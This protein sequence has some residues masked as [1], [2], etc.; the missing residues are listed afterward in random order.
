MPVSS[1]ACLVLCLSCPPNTQSYAVESV[2]TRVML[3]AFLKSIFQHQMQFHFNSLFMLL[4]LWFS[5]CTSLLPIRCMYAWVTS[6]EKR[7][8]RGRWK[9]IT[10]ENGQIRVILSK[11]VVVVVVVCV[12]V[13]VCTFRQVCSIVF[14]LFTTHCES[15]ND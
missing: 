6:N 12:C 13:C 7:W 15:L 14:L 3:T 9:I 10:G 8:T 5:L 11:F 2:V 1:C 4:S